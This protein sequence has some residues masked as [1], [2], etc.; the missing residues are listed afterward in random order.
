MENKTELVLISK[1][2]KKAVAVD[3]FGRYPK[4]QKVSVASDGQAFITDDGDAAAKNHAKN[5]RYK[6][7]LELT[8]FTRDGLTEKEATSAPDKKTAAELI[9]LIEAATTADEVNAIAEGDKR[10]TVVAAVT[11]KLETLK[12]VE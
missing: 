6:K 9:K 11:A 5:N 2:D 12:S 7:E 10:A 8:P 4:A 1:D 3:I